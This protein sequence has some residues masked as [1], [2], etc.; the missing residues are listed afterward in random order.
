MDVA[1]EPDVIGN[2]SELRAVMVGVYNGAKEHLRCWL[3]RDF[4]GNSVN[5]RT[6]E[7][8]METSVRRM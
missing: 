4:D 7:C 5:M 3:A 2:A 6:N 8:W 1:K